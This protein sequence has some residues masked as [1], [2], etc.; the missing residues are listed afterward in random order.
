M[1]EKSNNSIKSELKQKISGSSEKS[2][3]ILEHPEDITIQEYNKIGISIEDK[4]TEI[5]NGIFH[6]TKKIN[7]KVGQLREIKDN[8][9]ST[10]WELQKSLPLETED[11]VTEHFEF[12]GQILSEPDV[13][14]EKNKKGSTYTAKN[15]NPN[16]NISKIIENIVKNREALKEREQLVDQP[17]SN[18]PVYNTY[19]KTYADLKE[20]EGKLIQYDKKYRNL[21]IEIQ[22]YKDTLNQLLSMEKECKNII[23]YHNEKGKGFQEISSLSNLKFKDIG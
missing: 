9:K 7:E 20:K 6:I 8:I 19:L 17:S 16:Q 23:K 13:E 12:L 11:R 3:K 15:I 18:A 4:Y 2:E 22:K 21:E 10:Q 1:Q 14:C 5:S